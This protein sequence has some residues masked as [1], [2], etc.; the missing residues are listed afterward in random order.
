MGRASSRAA[1]AADAIA[2]ALRFKLVGFAVHS[3]RGFGAYRTRRRP[4]IG[5]TCGFGF[6][7][8]ADRPNTRRVSITPLGGMLEGPLD[9][10]LGCLSAQSR[11]L[12]FKEARP[13]IGLICLRG[14]P[15]IAQKDV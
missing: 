10:P 14:Q 15:P 6:G 2:R 5:E 8:G 1:C 13:R 12:G 4:A 9:D 3:I 7:S 11:Y